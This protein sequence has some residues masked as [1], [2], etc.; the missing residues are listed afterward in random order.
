MGSS[1][2]I[3]AAFLVF[4]MQAG[5]LLI[6]A[7]SV[8]AK[9]SVNVAQKN[10][11][12]MIICIICYSLVGFS[13]M[14]GVSFGG[15]IG[16][17]G[18]KSA[19]QEQGG[20]PEL[21]IFNLA[22][23]SVVA[24]IV[25]GAVAE[26]MRIGAYFVSTA[27]I[28]M[29]I[30]PILGHWT[31]GNMIIKSNLAYLANLGFIDHAGGVTIHALGGF[32]AL[33]AIIVLGPR[34]GRFNEK[35]QVQPISGFSPVLVLTGGLILFVTWIPFNTGALELGTKLFA[36][37][38]LATVIAGAAGGLA[39]KISGYILNSRTL[40]PMASANGILG[41]LVAVTAGASFLG[42]FGAFAIGV[43]GG[44]SAIIG[45]H[46]L[47]HRFKVDDP[48]GVVGVHGFAAVFGAMIFPFLT[49]QPLPKGNALSQFAVQGFGAFVCVAWA[50]ITGFAVI[51]TLK[52][53]GVLR[54]TAAQEYLGLN[55][56]E[57]MPNLSQEHI[58]AGY[59][60]SKKAISKGAT[61]QSGKSSVVGSEIGLA[62]SSMSED[63]KRLS[64]ESLI[65][66]A[67]FTEAT[68]SL[69][70]GLLIYDKDDQ[71]L[72]FNSAFADIMKVMKAECYVGMSRRDYLKE[73]LRVG[74]I[75]IGDTPVDVWLDE[76]LAGFEKT[77]ASEGNIQ[78]GTFYYI[79]RTRPIP[80]GGQILTITDVTQIKAALDKAK[81]AEKAKSEFLANMSHEI[82]TPMNGIIGMTELLS[83]SE[84]TDRQHH[85]VST[86]SSS[87]NALMTIINDILDFSKIEAGQ[88][89][90]NPVPFVLRDSIE[91][92]TTMLSSSAAEKNL[93][94][95]VR[96]QPDLPA[97]YIGDVGRVRQVLT[98]LVGNALKFTH[99]GH[100]LVDVSGTSS[101]DMVDLTIRVEDTGIGI[102]AEQ[103]DDIFQKFR[104]VDGTTTRE[105]EG[106][107]LGLSISSNLIELMGGKITVSSD[108]GKGTVFTV[109]LSL[110]HHQDMQPSRKIPVEVIGANI[111]IV[112]DNV[113]NRNI[114]RE[115][116]KH[117]KCRSVAM[118]SATKGIKVLEN[119]RD[120]GI[121]ID[122]IITDYHM[123]SLNGEDFFMAL[124]QSE[125]F[126]DI[127]M[128]ML[129][130]VNEDHM[131]QRLIEQGLA[132]ILTKPTRS[133]ILLDTITSCLFDAQKQSVKVE[134]GIADF[135]K[136]RDV[137]LS[138][139]L[140]TPR[141]EAPREIERRLQPRAD[142][143][144]ARG[145][146]VLIAEDNETNQVYIKYIM[147]ELG[148]TFKIVPTGRAAVDFW[149]SYNPSIILM[150][151][152][153]P[154]MNGYEATELI[155]ADEKKYN[156]G[157]TPI[158]AVTAHT[159]S[160]DEEKCIDAG[161]DDYLSKP[162]S[163]EGLEAKAAKWGVK[164]SAKTG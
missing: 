68:E 109:H 93:D 17:G 83:R 117:W 46:I 81:M 122:L 155:R 133:S 80:T 149:R 64:E 67:M 61:L 62:L 99:F 38:A 9:N 57:H 127:P 22:F 89:K 35:G 11:S 4:L 134:K 101:R 103:I 110:P 2:I 53:L 114:L 112:D 14:Y 47:L 94:L 111:L 104:Q 164:Y 162:V 8:R 1:W 158:I 76:Y 82:R 157:H 121:K 79:Y 24:T 151:I 77:G 84:L 21:L 40:D 148:L 51:G 60:A 63:N 132:A 150:D 107:G 90:L 125:H 50:L 142:A 55:L 106:T 97:T 19:L 159:L 33:A 140:P 43:I 15:Y 54:V 116:V 100:V 135:S 20:W 12:D 96:M 66:S 59:Q 49:S 72:E 145:L 75:Q 130:S 71:I 45:N 28:A 74:A 105:Y 108:V 70:D 91:D 163:I 73:L 30:Y 124:K 95:L 123:P 39:G 156:K 129:T 139:A 98:N 146:D 138:E 27:L 7:G 128:I 34:R 32:Y 126:S 136:D 25:S 161:M 160:G 56:G 87:G 31:W 85:F 120:K 131:T 88:V 48:V 118:E 10:V 143:V 36:D 147:E 113:V 102:P 154:D 16:M 37:V 92:V 29:F 153:M 58:E 78:V 52:A 5:F 41:G 137:S 26:R 141:K 44:A 115:Q 23:C 42:P 119:A 18:V 6:E 152:S 86:I 13:V 3:I 144:N 69:T 65:R